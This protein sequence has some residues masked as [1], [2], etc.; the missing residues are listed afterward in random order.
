MLFFLPINPSAERISRICR[1]HLAADR[2]LAHED[3]HFS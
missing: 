2:L 1:S 3:N